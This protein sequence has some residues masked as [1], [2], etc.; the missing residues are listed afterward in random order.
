[1]IV[2]K[3]ERRKEVITRN[4][5]VF[6][7]PLRSKTTGIAYQIL[8]GRTPKV[9]SFRNNI[10]TEIFYIIGGSGVIVVKNHEYILRE[11][12]VYIAKPKEQHF[13][14]GKKLTFLVITTPNWYPAQ[15][16]ILKD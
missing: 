8:S 9:G 12:D 4:W 15:C 1:M 5:K 16:E 6:D 7:Y 11:G 13:L 3:K 14:V 10:C 2:K